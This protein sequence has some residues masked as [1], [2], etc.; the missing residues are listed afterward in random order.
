M[1][2][3]HPAVRKLYKEPIRGSCHILRYLFHWSISNLTL[4][5]NEFYEQLSKIWHFIGF[6]DN[7]PSLHIYTFQPESLSCLEFLRIHTLMAWF[8]H[9]WF[10]EVLIRLFT[11]VLSCARDGLLPFSSERRNLDLS[12][13]VKNLTFHRISNNTCLC[14]YSCISAR[15][16]ELSGIINDSSINGIVP[17]YCAYSVVGL[18]RQ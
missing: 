11:I 13:N 16:L 2:N 9:N 7:T 5:R 14:A 18:R 8:L 12:A 6:P 4:S 1:N 15:K 10:D 17:A 3:A